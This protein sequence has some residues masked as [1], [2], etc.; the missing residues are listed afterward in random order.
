[1]S[2]LIPRYTAGALGCRNPAWIRPFRISD[3]LSRLGKA[4]RPDKANKSTEASLRR[5]PF[6]GAPCRS[7][8]GPDLARTFTLSRLSRQPPDRK[9]G[10]KSYEKTA[11]S[12]Q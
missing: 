6:S 12:S 1:M 9:R 8:M 10:R 4:H 2:T 11:Q 3:T 5:D 7:A